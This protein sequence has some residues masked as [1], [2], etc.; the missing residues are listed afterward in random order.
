MVH[1]RTFMHRNVLPISTR[2][3]V[4][5]I[6]DAIMNGAIMIAGVIVGIG[7]NMAMIAGI[8]MA[9]AAIV[10]IIGIMTTK[11]GQGQS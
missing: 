9:G 5:F 1:Q 2:H 10:D 11:F 4:S 6:M 3:P 7:V 8:V